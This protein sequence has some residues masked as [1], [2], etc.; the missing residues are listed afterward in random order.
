MERVRLE[1]RH[2]LNDFRNDLTS[3]Q[4]EA[5]PQA[6]VNAVS[7]TLEQSRDT[8]QTS[9][10]R[11]IEGGPATRFI[12][13]LAVGW[14]VGRNS[15]ISTGRRTNIPTAA[16]LAQTM[17]GRVFIQDAQETILDAALSGATVSQ[18]E[19]T[20]GA[21]QS[22]FNIPDNVRQLLL[23]GDR[24][25]RNLILRRNRRGNVVSYR[26]GSLGRLREAAR[27]TPSGN[28]PFSINSPSSDAAKYFEVTRDQTSNNGRQLTA[29][30]YRRESNKRSGDALR[31]QL[32]K[33]VNYLDS[34]RYSDSQLHQQFDFDRIAVRVIDSNFIPNM[35][36]AVE[37]ELRQLGFT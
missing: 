6:T 17:S 33:V 14:N 34:A 20:S 2:Q 3:M 21:T 29:G 27:D 31:T 28:K 4:M 32:T 25:G 16:Q 8:L 1:L 18:L 24:E 10:N 35:D 12:S 5:M 15:R 22:P 26:R 36:R 11:S 30:I 13:D 23:S 9:L 37:Q 7:R 19:Y